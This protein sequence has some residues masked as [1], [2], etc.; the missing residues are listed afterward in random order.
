MSLRGQERE[1]QQAGGSPLRAPVVPARRRDCCMTMSFCTVTM[2]APAPSRSPADREHAEPGA[3]FGGGGVDALFEHPQLDA[4]VAQR[5]AEGDQVQYGAAE[6]VQAGYDE[7][8]AGAQVAQEQ[9]EL[10]AA[11][12]GAA[13]SV[14]VDVVSGDAGAAQGVELVGGVLLVG[15]DACVP[16]QQPSCGRQPGRWTSRSRRAT[17]PPTSPAGTPLSSTCGTTRTWSTCATCRCTRC[18]PQQTPTRWSPSGRPVASSSPRAA[19]TGCR[20]SP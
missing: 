15:G 10:W 8:V 19:P 3:A 6:P 9:V 18:T 20:T 4:P 13:C 12:F 14:E 17:S 16:E 5:G 1:V 11:G 2:S 7:G